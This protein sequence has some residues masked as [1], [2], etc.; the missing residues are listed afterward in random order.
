MTCPKCGNEVNQEETFC[1]QCGTSNT[2]FT[3]LPERS[4]PPTSSGLLGTYGT[5][6][7]SSLLDGSRPQLLS[8]THNTNTPYPPT[9]APVYS[10]SL[11]EPLIPNQQAINPQLSGLHADATEAMS[12]LLSNQN[13]HSG[14]GY[15]PQLSLPGTAMPSQFGPPMQSFQSSNSAYSRYPQ[16]PFA[17]GQRYEHPHAQPTHVQQKHQNST[18]IL[19]AS[20]CLVVVLI[21]LIGIVAASFNKAQQS[22][23]QTTA[24]TPSPVA[25]I[26]PTPTPS[27]TTAPTPTPSPT[28]LP[29]PIPDVGFLWCGPVCA[30]DSFMTEYPDTWQPGAATNA[31]GIQFM[32]PAQPDQYAAFKAEGPT[33]SP[34]GTLLESDL[35]TN[36][37][38]KANYEPPTTTST[39]TISGETWATAIVYYQT[40]TQRERVQVY[41][42]VH[43]GNAYIIELQ[44]PDSQ[45]DTVNAQFF[46]VM[47]NKFQFLQSTP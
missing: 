19:V 44:A 11:A 1:G 42:T 12:A 33:T 37:A 32:N 8:N 43:Q 2:F 30:N 45:F 3:Q 9:V 15:P 17:T 41:A 16:Q 34:A 24:S 10:Q 25:T 29:T 7:A 23:Q 5:N 14:T 46:L 22:N 39:A 47:L 4:S 28:A 26:A 36:F 13:Q 21:S 38:V 35:Q 18:V 40:D 20:I 6:P 27:P 31:G